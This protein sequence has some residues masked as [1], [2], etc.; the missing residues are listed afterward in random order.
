M[1]G[2]DGIVG[3]HARC[4][5][6]RGRK[7]E[8]PPESLKKTSDDGRRASI[9]QIS[10]WMTGVRLSRQNTVANTDAKLTSMHS[11]NQVIKVVGFVMY[12]DD[13]ICYVS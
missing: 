3:P 11:L 1:T 9:G 12:E 2:V 6:I 7:I 13:L 8:N 5:V 10:S 4:E